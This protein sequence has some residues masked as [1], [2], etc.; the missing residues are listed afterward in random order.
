MDERMVANALERK[1]SRGTEA[2]YQAA[3]KG[4]FDTMKFFM[5]NMGAKEYKVLQGLVKGGHKEKFFEIYNED[6]YLAGNK[7]KFL[8]TLS[9]AYGHNIF[10]VEI[11]I[12]R[13]DE[14]QAGDM[15]DREI[16]LSNILFRKEYTNILSRI[17]FLDEIGY[18]KNKKSIRSVIGTYGAY[19]SVQ[20]NTYLAV[21][22]LNPWKLKEHEN[23]TE[24]KIPHLKMIH[25]SVC[26]YCFKH[27]LM[28]DKLKSIYIS[29]SSPQRSGWFLYAAIYYLRFDIAD[30]FEEDVKELGPV[31]SILAAKDPRIYNYLSSKGIAIEN[32]DVLNFSCYYDRPKMV[33]Y[34]VDEKKVSVKA[35][36][37]QI[38]TQANSIECFEIIER[39]YYVDDTG[40]SSSSSS[41]KK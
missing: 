19:D 2:A 14:E 28:I 12:P 6:N 25:P 36:H 5:D 7:N 23:I 13:K 35:I 30:E 9:L 20:G 31:I 21:L 15:N 17:P 26:L 22:K 37:L 27:G 1:A 34:L 4:D 41:G 32:D 39:Y 11:I 3:K 10:D 38:C 33:S 8:M 29:S 24:T 16:S 40:G 18:H